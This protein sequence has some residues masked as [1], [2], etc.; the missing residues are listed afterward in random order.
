MGPT[1]ALEDI[2]IS[3]KPDSALSQA[4]ME[5]LMTRIDSSARLSAPDHS[6][7]PITANNSRR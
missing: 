4:H 7:V 2:I 6:V 3:N 1:A 5:D